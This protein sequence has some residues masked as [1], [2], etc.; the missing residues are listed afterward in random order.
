MNEST[1]AITPAVLAE[2]MGLTVDAVLDAANGAGLVGRYADRPLTV[3]N[4]AA[5]QRELAGTNA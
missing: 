3:S 1:R 5:I 4:V 2:N